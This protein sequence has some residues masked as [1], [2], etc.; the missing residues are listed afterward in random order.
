MSNPRSNALNRWLRAGLTTGVTD[1]LFSS[2]L[3][4]AFYHST[5]ARL[6]QGVASTVIGP[7]AIGGGA[8]PV[9]MGLVMHF[10][11]ALTWSAIF[12]VTFDRP[13]WL[14]SV[15]RTTGGALIV[16]AILGPLIWMTM[17]MAVIPALTHRPVSIN[18]RWWVQFF[19]H[20]PFVAVPIVMAVRRR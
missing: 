1:G 2:V 17:S 19:G 13:G 12:L 4:A 3:S 6:W 8:A 5:V 14:R 9:A 16:A 15:A 18:F 20:I 7:G 10:G 11:V